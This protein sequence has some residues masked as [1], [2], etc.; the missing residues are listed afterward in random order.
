M[1]NEPRLTISSV[2]VGRSRRER[3]GEHIHNRHGCYNVARHIQRFM[4]T[5]VLDVFSVHQVGVLVRKLV[6]DM[7]VFGANR[8]A[9]GGSYRPGMPTCLLSAAPSALFG[10]HAAVEL[11]TVEPLWPLAPNSSA[12][13]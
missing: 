11:L 7:Q 6:Q 9:E 1:A 2:T 8:L 12:A 3:D 5:L 13:S 10:S 4:L